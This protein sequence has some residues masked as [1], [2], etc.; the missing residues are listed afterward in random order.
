M[1]ELLLETE[2]LL[3]QLDSGAF[4]PNADNPSDPTTTTATVVAMFDHFPK[5]SSRADWQSQPP[6]SQYSI[7]ILLQ[8]VFSSVGH[9]QRA[10]SKFVALK[11]SKCRYAKNNLV[12]S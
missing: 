7:I 8:V 6:P 9:V 5:S 3:R 11:L 4:D 12:L 2:D 1:D 10:S